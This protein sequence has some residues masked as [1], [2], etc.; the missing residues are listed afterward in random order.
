VDLERWTANAA[1]GCGLAARCSSSAWRA[2]HAA[3]L[4]CSLDCLT[5]VKVGSAMRGQGLLGVWEVCSGCMLS[6]LLY[7][8]ENPL[9]YMVRVVAGVYAR[10]SQVGLDHRNGVKTQRNGRYGARPMTDRKHG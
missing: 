9:A 1:G 7:V 4:V 6:D 3:L 10:R 5:V 8:F 2:S